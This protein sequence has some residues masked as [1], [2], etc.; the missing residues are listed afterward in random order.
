M[1]CNALLARCNNRILFG[2]GFFQQLDC[3]FLFSNLLPEKNE[4]P[5]LYAIYAE[6]LTG[7]NTSA[8]KLFSMLSFESRFHCFLLLYLLAYLFAAVDT[9]LCSKIVKPNITTRASKQIPPWK[10]PTDT[11]AFDAIWMVRS[12]SSTSLRSRSWYSRRRLLR[13]F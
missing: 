6:T 2:T 3:D 5:N 9:N 13:S 10:A 7:R 4:I 8:S 12:L 11:F 1:P